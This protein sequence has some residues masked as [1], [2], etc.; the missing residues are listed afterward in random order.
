MLY[1]PNLTNN[2]SQQI[3]LTGIQG[4]SIVMTL[5]FMP[6]IQQW[7]MGIN[8]G[9]FQVNGIAVVTSLNLLRKWKNTLSYGIACTYV[10]GLDPY[11]INDFQD[12]NAN[13]FL[14]DSTDVATIE[15]DWFNGS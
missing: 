2:A 12:L 11:Q 10:N 8:D 1:I 3:T 13:L 4:I 7:V 15:A 6:R 14:L 5:R 9:T